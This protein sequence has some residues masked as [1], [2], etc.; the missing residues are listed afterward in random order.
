M[1]TR[2]KVRAEAPGWPGIF[3]GQQNAGVG[4]IDVNLETPAGD[5]SHH[6]R[7]RLRALAA[8]SLRG[9][10]GGR[11]DWRLVWGRVGRDGRHPVVLSGLATAAGAIV[12][13]TVFP[14]VG[15]DLSAALARADWA[16]RYPGSAYIFSW[17]GGIHPASYSLL[18]PYLLAAIGT[19]L[20]MA[21]AA[22]L[23]A[24]LLAWLLVRHDVPRPRAAAL[25][26]AAALWT[27]LSAGRAAFT[28]GL[29]AA[30]GC[31]V[32]VGGPGIVGS[33]SS[34][35]GGGPSIVGG[36]PGIVGG[37]PGIVGGSSSLARGS[38]S[39]GWARPLAAA[40]L[41]L[42]TCLLSPV[43]A[44]FLGVVAVA[45]ASTG[46]WREGLIVGVA[47]GFP[48]GIMVVFS[49]GGVQPIG[50][51]N[52][53][54]PLLAAAGVLLL[55]PRRWRLVRIGAIIYGLGVVVT[56][57]LPTPVGS[58][59]GRLGE[60]LVGPVLAG[61][62]S[63]RHRWLLAAGLVAAAGWQ[64]AQP[65]A[66]LS[67][68]NAVA[69]APQT[70]ALVGEL[71]VLHADTARVEAVP[72][73]G[74][75]ESQELAATVPLARGWERQV[76]IERNPLFYSGTL[77]PEAYYGW[78]RYNAVR[79]VAIST[80]SPDFAAVAE[81]A[82]V[83]EGQPWLVPVWHNA[84]WQLLRVAGTYPLA[85]PPATVTRTTPAEITLRMSRAGTTIVRVRWSPLLR[86]TGSARL[87][88]R[89]A[90]TS[91]TA[92]QPGTYTLSAP[93]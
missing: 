70:A 68:G 84:F 44:L 22:V 35:V 88:R 34:I 52:W 39:P 9:P 91:L 85:S 76:D 79:Y 83:S 67:H 17:Y 73:Y 87:A 4:S 90:W 36:G 30:L 69:Y 19:R 15:T 47:A 59:V 82:V 63:G 8:W 3:A 10:E 49:D 31:A 60:L 61:M 58:N 13:I 50:V 23:S 26:V 27:E 74:H 5:A 54:P 45:L 81:A 11:R 75:W 2:W 64:V 92:R 25:W 51:Q 77:T 55:V 29:A 46:R 48:L 40:G 41:A 21:T 24:V 93:Y 72:Q 37:A 78:L 43:A 28:L 7:P 80:A 18:A 14:R 1:N 12:W 71:R 56:W 6:R 38:H 86:S 33:S 66:D 16:S 65:I 42:L 53:L 32:A 20:A 62:G 89:G 57:A